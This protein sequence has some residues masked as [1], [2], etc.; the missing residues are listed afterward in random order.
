MTERALLHSEDHEQPKF[1]PEQVGD[2]QVEQKG[3]PLDN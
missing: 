2:L 3:D 1:N